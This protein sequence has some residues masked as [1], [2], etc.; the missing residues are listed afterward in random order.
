MKT[1]LFIR[2]ALLFILCS[3]TTA[4]VNAS[5]DISHE[6]LLEINSELHPN[7]QP[8]YLP[9]LKQD[10]YSS[11]ESRFIFGKCKIR[12]NGEHNGVAYDMIVVIS[13]ISFISCLI[14]KIGDLFTD[15]Y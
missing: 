11:V 1:L 10:L 15:K 13:D 9:S 4:N 7:V 2:L 12:V 6:S 14:I 3:I 5:T 8:E